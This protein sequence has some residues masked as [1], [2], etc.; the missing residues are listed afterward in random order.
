MQIL[1]QY[2]DVSKKSLVKFAHLLPGEL[3]S[4]YLDTGLSELPELQEKTAY[5][6]PECDLF[7]TDS[8]DNVKLSRLYFEGQRDLIEKSA[9]ERIDKNIG[10]YEELYNITAP[11]LLTKVAKKSSGNLELLPGV[12]IASEEDFAAALKDFASGYLDLDMGDR[13][14]F[15]A[16]AMLCKEAAESIPDI[17]R[18]Y[19]E[20]AVRSGAEIRQG[21][22]LRKVAC[23]CAGKSGDKYTALADELSD[24]LLSS[25]TR[26]DFHKLAEL[27]YKY[28][29]TVGLTARKY[30]HKLP[31]AWQTVF[32]TA[33]DES[34]EPDA[35]KDKPAR[36]FTKADVI[37]RFGEASLDSVEN[38]DGS[39]NQQRVKDLIR[40]FGGTVGE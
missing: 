17:V 4:E 26:E 16:N 19:G 34:L 32:K 28:D 18:I 7:P 38:T 5:A 40:M 31:D 10:L 27:I 25:G 8:P 12:K 13:V 30:D 24:S 11:E 37:G 21:L 33:G 23:M 35:E 6:W 14:A 29:D 20:E 39:L 3:S 36:E 2:H 15:S 1:D 9:A 22:E